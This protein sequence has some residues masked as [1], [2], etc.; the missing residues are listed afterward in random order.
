LH[1][2]P[3]TRRGGQWPRKGQKGQDT[4]YVRRERK[5]LIFKGA[6][7]TLQMFHPPTRIRSRL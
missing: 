2:G 7:V 1:S 4:H 3:T 6:D 5:V